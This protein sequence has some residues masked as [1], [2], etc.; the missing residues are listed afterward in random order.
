[1]RNL[2]PS[3]QRGPPHKEQGEQ[4]QQTSFTF[5][6][7]T[8]EKLFPLICELPDFRWPEPMRGDPTKRDHNKKCTYHKEPGHA[9]EQ[10]RSLHYLVEKLL[11]AGH[12]KQYIC[13]GAK[14][15]ES[16]HDRVPRVPSTPVRAIIN[17]VHG[18]PLDEEYNSK[19]KRQR[20]LRVAFVWEHVSFIRP[21]LASG[22]AH[23]IDGAIVFP[24]IDPARVLQPHRDAL[25]LTLGIGDFDVKRILVDPGSSADLLQVSVVKQMGFIPS[26]LENPGRILSRFN[27]ASTTSLR[28]IILPIQAGLITLNVQLFVVEDLSPFNAILGRTLLHNMK[29]IPFTYHQMVSFITQDGQIESFEKPDPALTTS[30]SPRKRIS[31]TNSNYNIQRIRITRRQI[32]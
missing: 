20:L 19:R 23:P 12:L 9:T 6:T 7:L 4:R 32:P 1:M 15:G 14:S 16:S 5:L 2:K 25:I 26:S 8:Y 27:G 13:T 3:G 10:C 18:E 21:S 22:S 11:R 17:Y 28:D 29:A 30:L 31:P 24:P